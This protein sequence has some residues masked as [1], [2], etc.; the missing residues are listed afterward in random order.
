VPKYFYLKTN[1]AFNSKALI[2]RPTT[3]EARHLPSEHGDML[4]DKINN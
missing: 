1:V 2:K 4:S 3:D